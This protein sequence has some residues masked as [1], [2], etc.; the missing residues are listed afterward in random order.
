MKKTSSVVMAAIL[1]SH[2]LVAI[3]VVAYLMSKTE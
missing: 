2:V 3:F 1:A